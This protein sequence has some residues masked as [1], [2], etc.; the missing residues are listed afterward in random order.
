MG[1]HPKMAAAQPPD[2]PDVERRKLIEQLEKQAAAG[3]TLPHRDITDMPRYRAM[4][5]FSIKQ[6]D[7]QLARDAII[8]AATVWACTEYL[9]P[10]RDEDAVKFLAGYLFSEGLYWGHINEARAL[11][12][13]VVDNWL[14]SAPFNP[15]S[16]RTYRSLLYSA[17]RVL[18]PGEYGKPNAPVA[19]RAKALKPASSDHVEY[20]YA[21]AAAVGGGL[22]RRLNYALDLSTAAGLRTEEIRDLKGRDFSEVTLSGGR[23]VVVIAVR[24]RGKL[25]RVVPVICPVRQERLMA[26]AVEVG[27]GY[28]F[29]TAAGGRPPVGAVSNT[30]AEL[31]SKGYEGA[32]IHEL[33]NRWLLDMSYSRI[34]AA[35]LARIC[36]AGLF[37]AIADHIPYLETYTVIELAEM[38]FEEQER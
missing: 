24:R 4:V 17:G 36:G 7:S 19:K 3:A 28:F 6:P 13:A 23:R 20:L 14:A 8:R 34:P 2:P 11:P 22:G 5:K 29:P 27:S 1:R 25:D 35:A 38:L 32:K 30:F 16:A 10:K 26:R 33:R 15:N 12:R 37:T 21:A 31:R 9:S 18:Y